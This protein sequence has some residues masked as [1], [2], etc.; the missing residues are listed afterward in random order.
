MIWNIVHKISHVPAA[1]CKEIIIIYSWFAQSCAWIEV[2]SQY[3]R[4]KHLN[5]E[6]P[7]PIYL[8]IIARSSRYARIDVIETN[9]CCKSLALKR[10]HRHGLKC[11]R[12]FIRWL[13][14][15]TAVGRNRDE[16]LTIM[17]RWFVTSMQTVLKLLRS[18]ISVKN[19]SELYQTL[20]FRD[21]QLRVAFDHVTC[22]FRNKF[23]SDLVRSVVLVLPWN[24]SL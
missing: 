9:F 16:L 22:C 15:L 3:M 14:M 6:P 7:G 12:D 5:R 11:S 13:W 24:W 18:R 1:H 10:D 19:F 20:H 21:K 17:H 8:K 4:L 23:V 2:T